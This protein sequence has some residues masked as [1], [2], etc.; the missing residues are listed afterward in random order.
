MAT[1]FVPIDRDTPLLLPPNLRDWVGDQLWRDLQLD[2]FFAARLGC[3]REG[4]DWKKVLRLLTL[5]RLLSPG[6]E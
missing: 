2:I 5:Y 4:T 1:R 3:S 6:S